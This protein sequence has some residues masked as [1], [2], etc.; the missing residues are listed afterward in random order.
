ML[1]GVFVGS[2]YANAGI[3]CLARCPYVIGL[4]TIGCTNR[5]HEPHS[6]LIVDHTQTAPQPYLPSVSH[7]LCYTIY[8]YLMEIPF[9]LSITTIPPPH[10][11]SNTHNIPTPPNNTKQ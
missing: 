5:E 9:N 6:A 1:N 4:R 2:L 3:K 7:P 8:L 10:S 11:Y